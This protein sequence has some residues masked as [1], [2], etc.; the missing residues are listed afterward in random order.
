MIRKG[1]KPRF[2]LG[3]GGNRG[4]QNVW[5]FRRSW[6]A[7]SILAVMDVI[8]LIPAVATY[9]QISGDWSSFDS[10]FNGVGTVFL[11]AWLLGWS[12]APVKKSGSSW[13][14]QFMA[15]DYGANRVA[16]G[17]DVTDGDLAVTRIDIEKGSGVT[18]RQG[19]ALPGEFEDPGNQRPKRLRLRQ[20][21]QPSWLVSRSRCSALQ[22]W[23]S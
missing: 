22:P 15:V 12:T 11:G 23:P 13:R 18:I 10:L 17:S 3:F 14:G 9:A 20:Q 16:F 7:I 21:G 19:E 6:L 8:F 1:L 4:D 5:R 2:K